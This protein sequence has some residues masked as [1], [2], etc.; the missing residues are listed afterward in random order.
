M[1]EVHVSVCVCREV[2]KQD[3]DEPPTTDF[4]GS[5]PGQNHWTMMYTECTAERISTPHACDRNIMD[6]ISAF[7][8][9]HLQ[10]YEEDYTI[11]SMILAGNNICR[12]LLCI[13]LETKVP[14]KEE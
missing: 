5:G 4:L 3:G 14:R 10:R 1:Q 12:L 7:F 8:C 9:F 2:S 11:V 13:V 6:N